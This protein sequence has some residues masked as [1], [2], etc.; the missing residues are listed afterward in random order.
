MTDRPAGLGV[1]VVFDWALAAQLATQGVAGLGDHLGQSGGVG[2]LVARLA[3]AT[4]M[5]SAGE[6]LRRGVAWVRIAQIALAVLVTVGGAVAAIVLLSG[7]GGRGLALSAIV[8]LTFAPF[9][10]WRLALSRTARWFAAP[11][12]HPGAPRVSGPVWVGLLLAWS[13]AWGVLV[14]WSQSL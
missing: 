13:A 4:V 1:A 12:P 8:Q 11:R 10:V 6:A 2:G 9:I 7:G 5:A 3:G 14:A